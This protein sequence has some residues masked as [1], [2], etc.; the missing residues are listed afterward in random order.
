MYVFSPLS[1]QDE[2][3]F[4]S[5]TNQMVLHGVTEK[6]GEDRKQTS[7]ICVRSLILNTFKVKNKNFEC[8][9]L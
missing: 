8:Y 1:A 9:Y 3:S 5:N 2:F 4:I 7:G 6:P